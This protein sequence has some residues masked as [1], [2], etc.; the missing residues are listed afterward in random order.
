LLLSTHAV[1][2]LA[3]AIVRAQICQSHGG[4]F[5]HYSLALYTCA[6]HQPPGRTNGF[7]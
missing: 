5:Q 1:R 4:A 2:V 7:Q 6:Y 3:A